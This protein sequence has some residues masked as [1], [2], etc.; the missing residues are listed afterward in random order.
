MSQNQNQQTAQRSNSAV[1]GI[2]GGA[3]IG[4]LATAWIMNRAPEAKASAAPP[5]TAH[6]PLV[7]FVTA[8]ASAAPASAAP[9]S[10]APA[11]APRRLV[12]VVR[13]A[14]KKARPIRGVVVRCTCT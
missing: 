5:A 7:V 14:K 10:A 3:L 9:A 11:S 2:L 6:A 4:V 8:P 13:K 12:Y 1:M